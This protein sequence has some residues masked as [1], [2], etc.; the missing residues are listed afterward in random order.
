MGGTQREK[1]EAEREREKWD[2]VILKGCEQVTTPCALQW[3]HKNSGTSHDQPGVSVI[4][5]VCGHE[6]VNVP[7]MVDFLLMTYV[8]KPLY[9]IGQYVFGT[10]SHISSSRYVCPHYVGLVLISTFLKIC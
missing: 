2:A 9:F 1:E 5:I 6:Q 10:S 7:S 8:Q 4:L 3:Q